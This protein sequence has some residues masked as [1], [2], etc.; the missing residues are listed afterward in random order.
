MYTHA[1]YAGIDLPE[2]LL[3]IIGRSG[4][5][6]MERSDWETNWDPIS[7]DSARELFRDYPGRWWIAGGW[8]IELFVDGAGR[9]HADVDIELLRSEHH[10][11][12]DALPGWQLFACRVSGK[13]ILHLWEVGESLPSEVHDIWCRPTPE[14]PWA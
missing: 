10:L 5:G 11:I 14:S 6:D 13:E 1:G 2:C 7:I 12:H 4:N 8:C 3:G 9:E